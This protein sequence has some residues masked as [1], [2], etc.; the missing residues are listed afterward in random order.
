MPQAQPRQ[1]ELFRSWSSLSF[2]SRWD[3]GEDTAGGLRRPDGQVSFPVPRGPSGPLCLPICDPG[4]IMATWAS[5]GALEAVKLRSD[6]LLFPHLAASG[7]GIKQGGPREGWAG[8]TR[9]TTNGAAGGSRTVL[10]PGH[11][12]STCGRPAL[13]PCPW[14]CSHF[15]NDL[16]PGLQDVLWEPRVEARVRP[17]LQA[18][19]G[20]VPS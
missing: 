18:L 12:C 15:P 3:A 10:W 1:V 20:F 7:P 8:P 16:R 6:K 13:G 17:V 9:P 14:P 5:W 19:D 2:Y 11:Y 4:P